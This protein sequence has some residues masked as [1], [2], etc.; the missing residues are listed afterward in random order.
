MAKSTS[1]AFVFLLLAVAHAVALRQ[2]SAPD[3][4]QPA[5]LL[6]SELDASVC[7][8]IVEKFF[9]ACDGSH[10]ESRVI[11]L[12]SFAPPH[13]LVDALPKEPLFFDIFR[14]LFSNVVVS[15][16]DNLT[17]YAACK[18]IM[19]PFVE[20]KGELKRAACIASVQLANRDCAGLDIHSTKKCFDNRVGFFLHLVEDDHDRRHVLHE[21]ISP[22]IA[23]A[24]STEDHVSPSDLCENVFTKV[25]EKIDMDQELESLKQERHD[26][27][28]KPCVDA[29]T[30]FKQ[31]CADTPSFD[32]MDCMRQQVRLHGNFQAFSD[33]EFLLNVLVKSSSNIIISHFKNSADPNNFVPSHLCSRI[34]APVLKAHGDHNKAA[35]LMAFSDARENCVAKP[36]DE[37]VAC[38]DKKFEEVLDLI[39]LGDADVT[40]N[41]ME[42]ISPVMHLHIF[43]E[44]SAEDTC[45]EIERADR[46]HHARVEQKHQENHETS[47]VQHSAR[48][49]RHHN[50][51]SHTKVPKR[52][53]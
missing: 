38:Y 52:H 32:W 40:K 14:V 17:P 37:I 2:N 18:D 35:C 6:E 44:F 51:A 34:L 23:H 5:Y 36:N 12:E 43:D 25:I 3:A 21:A 39:G 7:E 45:D 30:D 22:F 31:A 29:F 1:A 41:V 53:H 33:D 10:G 49:R 8:K 24:V 15:K 46:E 42:V 11:C 16:R 19:S 20:A 27:T 47:L 4:R 48:L 9:S 26:E 13:E 28:I 50:P